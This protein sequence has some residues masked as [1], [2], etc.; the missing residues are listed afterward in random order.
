MSDRFSCRVVPLLLLG[1]ALTQMVM[2]HTL[3]LSPW[4][5]GGFGMFSTVDSPGMRFLAIRARDVDGQEIQV[6]LEET[7]GPRELRR[8]ASL[9]KRAFLVE[10]A[11]WLLEQ[12]LVAIENHLVATARTLEA[13]NPGLSLPA[14]ASVLA[15]LPV[16]RV[17][18]A[19]DPTPAEGSVR[20]LS[21]VR[22]E[23]WRLRVEPDTLRVFCEQLL[24]PVE[25][26]SW[27]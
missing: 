23:A 24:E 7:P 10:L 26:G 12:E 5:G 6:I 25:V 11:E 15:D 22:L 19:G 1:V 2:A 3:Q 16:Y 27:H 9:P 13:Q 8:F 21:G 20:R 4:K 14:A 17:R 18:R